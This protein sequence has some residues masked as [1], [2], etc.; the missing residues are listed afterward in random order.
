[1][2]LSHLL[3]IWARLATYSTKHDVDDDS[4]PF[5]TQERDLKHLQSS[6]LG[7]SLEDLEV[8]ILS[9][10]ENDSKQTFLTGRLSKVEPVPTCLDD[11]KLVPIQLRIICY[12]KLFKYIFVGLKRRERSARVVLPLCCVARIRNT[13]PGALPGD[14][15]L[16]ESATQGE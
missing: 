10:T 7:F 3:P 6:C 1:M 16:E 11:C 2:G 13:Y 8:N 4:C 15:A 12:Y 5:C 14:N 9:P